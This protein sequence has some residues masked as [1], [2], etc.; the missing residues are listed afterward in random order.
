[1][2][3]KRHRRL[4]DAAGR[5]AALGRG[6]AEALLDR[7]PRQPD[8]PRRRERRRD[9]ELAGAGQHIGS[10]GAARRTAARCCRWPMD[11]Y[12]LRLRDRPRRNWCEKVAHKGATVRLND[13]KVDRRGR[14]VD[15]QPRD[16]T[17]T[18]PLA[19]HLQPRHRSA[20]VTQIDDN[21]TVSNGPCWSPDHSIFYFADS[22]SRAIWAYDYDHR[23]RQ[24]LQQ[25]Q[26]RAISAPRTGCQTARRSIRKAASGAAGVYR[27]KIHRFDPSRVSGC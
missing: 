22:R 23:D 18:A 24:G 10:L 8:L 21:I 4:Q 14:F 19:M 1:M 15:R 12:T 5:R 13:G 17:E 7:Q 20:S 6:R 9:G 27:S 16:T 11:F 3:I 2:E 25:A 26:V